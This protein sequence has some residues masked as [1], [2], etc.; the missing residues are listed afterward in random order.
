MGSSSS[1]EDNSYTGHPAISE[2]VIDILYNSIT[3]IK[4]NGIYG[5]GFL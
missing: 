3:K 5:T 4:V 1:R 2:T